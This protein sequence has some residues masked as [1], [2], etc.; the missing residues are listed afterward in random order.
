MEL[1]DNRRDT[2]HTEVKIETHDQLALHVHIWEQVTAPAGIVQIIHGMAEHGARYSQFATYLNKQGFIVVADDHRGFGKS[3]EDS[4]KLGHLPFPDGF[5]AMVSDEETVA[6]F[7]KARYPNLPH[8]LFGHS[9]G[10]FVTRVLITQYKVDAAVLAGS[11]LQP[12]PLLKSGLFYAKL[13]AKKNETKRSKILHKLSFYGFNREF[14]AEKH[15]FS[16][17]SRDKAVHEAYMEDPFGGQ[18]VGSLGFYHS[19]LLGIE[20]SQNPVT[21]S[22]TPKNL[23]LLLISGS[24]DPVGHL[25]KDVPKLAVKFEK[26]DVEDVTLKIYEDARHEL[27]NEINKEQVF[28][29][30]AFWYRKYV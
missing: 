12:D 11:G 9:M 18:V 28:E 8:L 19:L 26:A 2:M 24:K 30:V 25:G 27:T 3:A 4:S 21:I 13:R 15:P 1:C 7:I 6:T 29:D 22:K 5:E 23:P 14:I 10:S 17:L 16:W 20:Q